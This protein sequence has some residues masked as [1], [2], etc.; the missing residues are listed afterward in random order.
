MLW[1]CRFSK[2][3][4]KSNKEKSKRYQCEKPWNFAYTT[5]SSKSL[6]HE[7]ICKYLQ[8]TIAIKIIDE[9]KYEKKNM[10]STRLRVRSTTDKGKPIDC[11]NTLSKTQRLDTIS[12][13][14]SN[15][16]FDSMSKSK[17]NQS[18]DAS[19]LKATS[20]NKHSQ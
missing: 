19:K 11:K 13:S 15:Q 4:S 9:H 2:L 1:L 10:S 6:N 3:L 5:N 18:F 20:S 8:I 16:C 14:M 17:S 7:K 12:K